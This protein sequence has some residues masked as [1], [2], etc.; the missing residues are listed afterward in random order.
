LVT[1]LLRRAAQ[2]LCP[3]YGRAYLPPLPPSSSIGRVRVTPRADWLL[4]QG[5]APLLSRCVDFLHLC[6]PCCLDS[7][8]LASPIQAAYVTSTIPTSRPGS[9]VVESGNK[10]LVAF[11]GRVDPACSLTNSPPPRGGFSRLLGLTT[12]STATSGKSSKRFLYI[13]EVDGLPRIFLTTRIFCHSSSPAPP[14]PKR[15]YLRAFAPPPASVSGTLPPPPIA[16]LHSYVSLTGHP[17]PLR[18]IAFLRHRRRTYGRQRGPEDAPVALLFVFLRPAFCDSDLLGPCLAILFFFLPC[19][20]RQPCLLWRRTG[21]VNLP[22]LPTPR[23]PSLAHVLRVPV[24]LTVSS[25]FSL[26]CIFL[27]SCLHD[28]SDLF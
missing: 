22:F 17:S 2:E 20:F 1:C 23:P 4:K 5:V 15:F 11:R 6:A 12:Y 26:C 19:S 24:P 8:S 21:N 7:S 13:Y 25:L 10:S 14:A 28:G 18:Y 3:Y 9:F 27:S 16:R